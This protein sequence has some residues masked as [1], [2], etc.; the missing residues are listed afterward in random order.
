MG[1]LVESKELKKII[2]AIK[3]NPLDEK[4]PAPLTKRSIKKIMKEDMSNTL[5]ALISNN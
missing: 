4:Y 3:R 2:E 1:L 5:K